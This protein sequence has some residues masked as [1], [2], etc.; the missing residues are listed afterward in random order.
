MALANGSQSVVPG[1]SLLYRAIHCNPIQSDSTFNFSFAIHCNPIQ[2][3]STFN[4]TFVQIRSIDFTWWPE[5]Q[6]GVALGFA[7]L[8]VTVISAGTFAF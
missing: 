1:D 5:F 7:S 6:N 2:S 8:F 3:D 4:F